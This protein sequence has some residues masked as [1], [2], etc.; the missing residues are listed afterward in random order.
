[1]PP[2]PPEAV[3]RPMPTLHA[4]LPPPPE[5]RV[6]IAV[7]GLGEFALNLILPALAQTQRCR[8][9]AVVSGD[10]KKAAKV[11]K[12]YGVP[13][14]AYTYD[15]FDQIEKDDTV[16]AVYVITPN[17]LHR[18]FAV[19][20]ARAGKHLLVEKPLD[21]TTRAAEAI[22]K[23]ADDAGRTLMTAYRAQFDPFNQK[24]IELLRKGTI[25]DLRT[26][27]ADHGRPLDLSAPRDTWRALK[28][29]AGGGPLMDVGIYA[30]NAM[31]YLTGEEPT[32]VTA[33]IDDRPPHPKADVES[34]VVW[35]MRFP[36]GVLATGSTSYT[37]FQIKRYAVVGE[38]GRLDMDPA[39]DYF[40]RRV[41]VE[42]DE[43]RREVAV[44]YGDQFAAMLDHF[45]ECVQTGK[46]PRTPGEEGV[47]DV[48]LMEA[49][50][51]AARTGKRL[52]L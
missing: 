32:E 8:L 21:V 52:P 2:T 11:A 50:Y 24:A 28:A 6:G 14:H 39:T 29:Y 22:V 25:G 35:T 13:D 48:R 7:V 17:A 16:D 51:K 46:T 4:P 37:G 9:A 18:P 23:A 5:K 3:G 19:R 34:A 43:G 12:A 41:F 26:I 15:T 1:M 44:E 10:E 20:S 49:I 40:D 45:A 42:N 36:S 47:R 30:L 27:I 33:T 38:K 31:R